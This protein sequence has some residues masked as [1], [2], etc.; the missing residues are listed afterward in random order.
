[1]SINP[2]LLKKEREQRHELQH[3][4]VMRLASKV[5]YKQQKYTV[6]HVPTGKVS[7][8]PVSFDTF[9]AFLMQKKP[10]ER[11][12]YVCLPC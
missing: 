7:K 9:T 11:K 8:K 2:V 6:R 4:Y 12:D 5:Q 10:S 1:M 3:K